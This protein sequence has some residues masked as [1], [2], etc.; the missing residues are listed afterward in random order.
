MPRAKASALST[1][2][3]KQD[4]LDAYNEL[5]TQAGQA[6]TPTLVPEKLARRHKDLTQFQTELH[7][8]IGQ[9]QTTLTEAVDELVKNLQAGTKTLESLL[10]AQASIEESRKLEQEKLNRQRKQEDEEYQYEFARRKQ[11]QETE[12]KEDLEKH[13]K[14]LGGKGKRAQTS[15]RRA[16]R[17]AENA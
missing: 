4:I 12:L 10:Q 9:L 17:A 8:Q 13:H 2:N 3:T 1:K 16:Q 11:R 6:E 15:R 5:L 7:T 14:L